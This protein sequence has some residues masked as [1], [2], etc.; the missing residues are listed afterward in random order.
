ME[1]KH[2]GSDQAA[3]GG[4]CTQART[5]V[6]PVPSQQHRPREQ[7][8]CIQTS[9][10]GGLKGSPWLCSG[11]VPSS[12]WSQPRWQWTPQKQ[13]WLVAGATGQGTHLQKQ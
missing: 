4:A 8:Q 6:Q 5:P 2:H 7:W 3:A 1:K 11:P 12:P 9:H 10:S 13:P